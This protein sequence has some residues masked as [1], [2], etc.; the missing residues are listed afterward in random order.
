MS[1]VLAF[2]KTGDVIPFDPIN[3][4]VLEF[5]I[6]QLNSQSLNKFLPL[7]QNKGKQILD[8]LSEL[9][10]CSIEINKWLHDIADIEVTV[11]ELEG[12]LDQK[13]LNKLHADW[14]NSQSLVYDIQKKRKQFNFSGFAEQLHDMFPDDIQHPSLST[15][16]EKLKLSSTYDLIN[17]PHVH[18]I[19]SMFNNIKFTVSS[20]WVN[21]ADNPFPKSILTNNTAN[22]SLSFNHLGR[23]LYDKFL[24]FD[25]NLEYDD[26][27]SFNELLGF[28][29]LSLTQP[30]TI[31]LS[32]EYISWCKHH[33]REPIGDRLN[34]GNIPNLQTNLTR[35]RTIMFKNMLSNNPFSIQKAKG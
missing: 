23:T 9:R 8:A 24:N 13:N 15:V 11:F 12:Y 4:D 6:D 32:N 1:F 3:Q 25:V 30:Q 22:L 28:V 16:L 27:N 26:E 7:V 33:N 18:S 10:K 2:D 34:I 35:Y 20:G 5:Y 19:E 21:V 31:P 17:S 29:T 14:V